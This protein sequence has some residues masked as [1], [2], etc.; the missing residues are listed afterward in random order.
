M[1]YDVLCELACQIS[2]LICVNRK[3]WIV[4]FCVYL[5]LLGSQQTQ[6]DNI[7]NLNCHTSTDKRKAWN[8]KKVSFFSSFFLETETKYNF[9]QRN[10][11]QETARRKEKK[12]FFVILITFGAFAWLLFQFYF[13]LF[14]ARPD[15]SSL[16]YRHFVWSYVMWSRSHCCWIC[17]CAS[18]WNERFN[19]LSICRQHFRHLEP[20]NFDCSFC[21]SIKKIIF[22]LRKK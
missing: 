1:L 12:S 8:R 9:T 4:F 3:N 18:I 11:I 6:I 22:H 20:W 2:Y 10:H 16:F 19:G 14:V 7:K 21:N 15:I 17:S 5:L 13:Y